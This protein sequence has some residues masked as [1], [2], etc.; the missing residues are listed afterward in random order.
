MYFDP[1]FRSKAFIMSGSAGDSELMD[2]RYVFQTM[3]SDAVLDTGQI[4]F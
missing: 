2:R 1:F 3:T 4:A